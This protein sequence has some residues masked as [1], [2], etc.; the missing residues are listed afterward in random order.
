[1]VGNW[2]M[3]RCRDRSVGVAHGLVAVEDQ[4]LA[5]G[6]ARGLDD[7]GHQLPAEVQPPKRRPHIQPLK[8]AGG[9]PSGLERHAA[10]RLARM[11][12]Q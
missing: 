2:P 6:L 11:A 1:M 8:L 12:G 7:G 10:G 4:A 3:R 9:R 5:A